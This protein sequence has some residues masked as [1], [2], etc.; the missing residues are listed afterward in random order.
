MRHLVVLAAGTGGHIMPGLAVAQEMQSRGWTVSWLGTAHG[1]ENR[2]VPPTGI[3]LDTVQFSGLRGKGWRHAIT[4]IRQFFS[5]WRESA[6]ILKRRGADAILGMGGYICLPAGLAAVMQRRPMMLVNADAGLLLSNRLLKPFARSIA[7]GFE[8]TDSGRTARA[9]VTGNPVRP[10]ISQLPVPQQRMAGR[11]GPLRLLVLGGSLGAQALNDAIPVAL[12]FMPTEQRP[13]V[14]HQAGA[15][16]AQL[17]KE[18]Y[19][20]LE[21]RADVRPFI[22]DMAQALAESDLVI[23]R[24]GAITVSELCAAG[25]ASVL[26]PLVISTTSHQQDNA[27][28]MAQHGAAIH[29]PQAQLSKDRLVALLKGMTRERALAMAQCARALARP[30][31]AARVADQIESMVQA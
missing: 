1:M 5:A 31:A 9:V 27:Q 14:I 6:A 4:G 11:T 8:G 15:A 2:L 3:E 23:C 24:A 12:A 16:H 22:E 26:V 7:F 25:V 17:L 19:E 20:W 28:W 10:Q 30:D 13:Q 18:A 29:L 21:V